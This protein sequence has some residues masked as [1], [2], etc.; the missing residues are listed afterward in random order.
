MGKGFLED[1]FGIIAARPDRI[2]PDEIHHDV[3][4][5]EGSA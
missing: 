5:H 2:G 3:L 4:V 1:I